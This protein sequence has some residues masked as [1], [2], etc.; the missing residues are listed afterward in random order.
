MSES[1]AP[2]IEIIPPHEPI[3]AKDVV[4]HLYGSVSHFLSDKYL[5][6]ERTFDRSNPPNLM[7]TFPLER[8]DTRLMGRILSYDD[9][10]H[11]A[12]VEK[13]SDGKITFHLLK[14]VNDEQPRRQTGTAVA[15][16]IPPHRDGHD[17]ESPYRLK[18]K[19]FRIVDSKTE[20]PLDPSSIIVTSSFAIDSEGNVHEISGDPIPSFFKQFIDDKNPITAGHF[21]PP[22]SNRPDRFS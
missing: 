9:Q 11:S 16:A 5:F 21:Y 4:K 1:G 22:G 8:I 7:V 18:I 15:A 12:L 10:D 17:D 13:T 6:S 19:K 2:K 20:Q 14:M 3:Y